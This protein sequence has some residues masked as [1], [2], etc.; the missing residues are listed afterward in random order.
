ML[1]TSYEPATSALLGFPSRFT[2]STAI[3]NIYI[4]PFPLEQWSPMT[5]HFTIVACVLYLSTTPRALTP[6]SHWLI[7]C[8]CCWDGLWDRHG[9]G[10][11][12][13]KARRNL[14]SKNLRRKP[15]G[16]SKIMN[17]FS[18]PFSNCRNIIIIIFT[19]LQLLISNCYIYQ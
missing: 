9:H 13:R 2:D 16:G 4:H 11:G 12:I 8:F 17:S 19:T 1:F 3:L 5:V 10:K 6:C 14:P 18:Q 15:S 7:D